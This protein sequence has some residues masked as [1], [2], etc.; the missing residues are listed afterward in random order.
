MAHLTPLTFSL[1]SFCS[2]FLSQQLPRAGRQAMTTIPQLSWS[3]TRRDE[4]VAA[5]ISQIYYC[6]PTLLMVAS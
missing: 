2:G 4:I 5:M 1:L 3:R 6:T